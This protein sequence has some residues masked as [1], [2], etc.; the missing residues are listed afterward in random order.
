MVRNTVK[1]LA[2]IKVDR[3]TSFRLASHES[4]IARR[5]GELRLLICLVEIP[6]DGVRLDSFLSDDQK[7]CH[8]HA[9]PAI[10]L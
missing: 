5:A 9:S 2:E 4:L 8:R 1:S 6:T 3:T 10:Y 7:L